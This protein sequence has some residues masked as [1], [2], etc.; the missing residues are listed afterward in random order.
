[1]VWESSARSLTK[2]QIVKLSK[3]F[4]VSPAAFLPRA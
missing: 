1:M 4:K 3:F 2:A